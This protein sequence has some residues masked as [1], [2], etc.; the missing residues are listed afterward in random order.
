MRSRASSAGKAC[1]MSAGRCVSIPAR[2]ITAE[3]PAIRHAHVKDGIVD[4]FRERIGSRPSID[5]ANPDVRVTAFLTDREATLYLD[6]PA[7]R[8]SSAAGGQA[9]RATGRRR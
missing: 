1:S 9:S 3:E 8:C 7:S 4:R 2:L 6:L 5:T